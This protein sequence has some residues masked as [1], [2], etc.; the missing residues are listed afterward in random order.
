[1]YVLS[2]LITVAALPSKKMINALVKD[3]IKRSQAI[4]FLLGFAV[5]FLVRAP[6]LPSHLLANKCVIGKTSVV[7]RAVNDNLTTAEPPVRV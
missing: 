1:M 4:G 7:R 2:D 6:P 5:C 3:P